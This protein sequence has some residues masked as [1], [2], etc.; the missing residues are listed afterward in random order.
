MDVGGRAIPP[1]L[2]PLPPHPS[3]LQ[4]APTLVM[5]HV[6]S[7]LLALIP[8]FAAA[9][10]PT[11]AV[12]PRP[13]LAL[14]STLVSTPML[15]PVALAQWYYWAPT[16]IH[17]PTPQPH[18]PHPHTLPSHPSP[19]LQHPPLGRAMK[20][21]ASRQRRNNDNSST[22]TTCNNLI[23]NTFTGNLNKSLLTTNTK[24]IIVRT[25]MRNNTT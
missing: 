25:D 5:S 11:T 3:M 18:S 7:P 24:T 8:A 13:T 20:T 15:T 19:K 21:R 12:A 22:R 14:P 2:L 1:V 16:R 4:G 23:N 10:A 9:H 17:N 6:T